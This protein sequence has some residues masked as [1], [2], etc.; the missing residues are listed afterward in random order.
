MTGG[1]P[2]N[3]SGRAVA[4]RP[5]Q[6]HVAASAALRRHVAEV[7]VYACAS[8]V[9]GGGGGGGEY[10]RP[11]VGDVMGDRW[12]LFNMDETFFSFFFFFLMFSY[13]GNFGSWTPAVL[14]GY[15]LGRERSNL[16]NERN[17]A[18]TPVS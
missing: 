1:G 14:S 12:L 13:T 3:L 6:W 18:F 9:P 16:R 7:A 2:A 17:V 4:I 8:F 11:L 10:V 15:K 5:R